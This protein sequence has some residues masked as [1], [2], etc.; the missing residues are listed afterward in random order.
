MKLVERERA[1]FYG[2]FFD[3]AFDI[4]SGAGLRYRPFQVI[5]VGPSARTVR[6]TASAVARRSQ[7]E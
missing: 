4:L 2:C 3:W 7:G 1:D 6:T 5:A